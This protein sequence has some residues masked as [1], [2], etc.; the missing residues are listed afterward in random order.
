MFLRR[1]DEG[2]NR[3]GATMLT[4]EEA[5]RMFD[6]IAATAAT[7]DRPATG[8]PDVA[9]DVLREVRYVKMRA[10]PSESTPKFC[11]STF[12]PAKIRR[13]FLR[14]AVGSGPGAERSWPIL[15]DLRE[16]LDGP[17]RPDHVKVSRRSRRGRC[18]IGPPSRAIVGIWANPHQARQRSRESAARDR[19]RI[20]LFRAVIS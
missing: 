13:G 17:K 12:T 4:R 7:V 11:Q 8:G 1:S 5:L 9:R 18:A 2:V 6:A 14:G 20:A 19:R 16:L 10:A 15:G 3:Q